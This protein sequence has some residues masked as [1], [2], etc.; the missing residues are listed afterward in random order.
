[1][2]AV[3]SFPPIVAPGARVLILGSM[4]GVASLSAGQY[5]A[6]PRNAFWRIL[7]ASLGFA[8]GAPYAERVAGLQAGGVAVWDVLR[9]CVRPGSL[10][11]AIERS[12]EVPNDVVGLLAEH[13]SIRRVCF[14][15]GTAAAA[16]RRHVS[17]ERLDAL[18]PLDLRALPSTS[19]A[20]AS[21]SFKRKLAAW[22]AALKE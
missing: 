2:S 16:F 1:M 10:D 19:P 18:G 21:W 14:N 7:G 17:P 12:S 9:T 6:H 15:G 13:P 8:A 3:E 22:S 4:P 11:A 5:Y 20:N